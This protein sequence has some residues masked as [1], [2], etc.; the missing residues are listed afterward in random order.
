[1]IASSSY[2]LPSAR[3]EACLPSRGDVKFYICSKFS[4]YC[5]G[6]GFSNSPS[7]LQTGKGPE[8]SR[9]TQLE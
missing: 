3:H 6:K 2:Q 9:E 8:M 1:M 7:N 5:Y 4:D